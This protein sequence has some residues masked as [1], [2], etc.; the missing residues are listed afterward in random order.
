LLAR[1]S[2][3]VAALAEPVP[4]AALAGKPNDK[5]RASTPARM[6]RTLRTAIALSRS[7]PHTI[8]NATTRAHFPNI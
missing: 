3:T 5:A 4:V 2:A 6:I 7:Y 8:P 1:Q